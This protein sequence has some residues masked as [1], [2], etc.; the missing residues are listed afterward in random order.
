MTPIDRNPDVNLDKEQVPLS[1]TLIRGKNLMNTARNIKVPFGVASAL[2]RLTYN[3]RPETIGLI[4]RDADVE[5]FNKAL[6]KKTEKRL[7]NKT[8]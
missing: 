3:S 5:R 4:I 7:L 1:M 8:K 2:N 6:E